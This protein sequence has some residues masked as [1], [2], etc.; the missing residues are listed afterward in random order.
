MNTT[1]RDPVCGMMAN[2]DLACFKGGVSPLLICNECVF[3]SRFSSLTWQDL[4]IMTNGWA[5]SPC[6]EG[7]VG[8]IP[9]ISRSELW[10]PVN[11]QGD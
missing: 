9:H 8:N 3:L 11:G 1:L 7:F 5:K 10:R 6:N 4:P 2:P